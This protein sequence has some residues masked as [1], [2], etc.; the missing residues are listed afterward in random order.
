MSTM[1][2]RLNNNEKVVK[3]G[4]GV[5]IARKIILGIFGTVIILG[6]IAGLFV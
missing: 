4:N 2:E 1:L 6:F 3:A 5:F